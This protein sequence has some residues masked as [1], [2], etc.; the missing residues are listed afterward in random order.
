MPTIDA[1]RS[2]LPAHLVDVGGR[3][4]AI[5]LG[6]FTQRRVNHILRLAGM[7]L[8]Y[9]SPASGGALAVWGRDDAAE[10]IAQSRKARLITI[11]DAFL[12]SLHPGRAG[13][14]PLG[15]MVDD[16]GLYYDAR[17]PSRL[18]HI[19]SHDPLDDGAILARARAVIARMRANHLSKYSATDPEA[20]APKAGYVLVLDQVKGDRAIAGGGADA[21]RFS[22]ML[23]CAMAEHPRAP[24]LIKSHPETAQ[25]LRAGYF[26][27]AALHLAD[28]NGERVSLYRG[29][30]SPWVLYEGAIAVYTVTS[31]G[32]FEA[33][34]AGHKPVTFGQPFYAGWGLSED[35]FPVARR[36]RRLTRAQLVAGAMILAPLW[37]DPHHRRL[38]Q[39][40]DALGHLE[41]QSRAW[42]ADRHGYVAYGM[43]AW[44]RPHLRHFFGRDIR[45]CATPERAFAMARRMGKPLLVWSTKISDAFRAQAQGLRV[46]FVEDGFLRSRG[47]GAAL[48]PPLSLLTDQGGP[49]YDAR[50]AS[51]LERAIAASAR[52]DPAL[53]PR[54]EGLITRIT[55]RGL[56]KYNLTPTPPTPPL[57]PRDGR[58]RVLVVGQVEDD[59]S[60]RHGMGEIVTNGALLAWAREKFPDRFL[61]YKPHPDVVAGLRQGALEGA[62]ADHILT[63][64]DAATILSE[65][66]HVVVMSSGMGFE[67]LLRGLPVSV[68]GMPFYAGWGLTDDALPRPQARRAQIDLIGLTHAALIA[69]PRYLDPI[70]GLPASVEVALDRIARGQT[71]RPLWLTL[72]AALQRPFAFGLRRL[73]R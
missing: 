3:V 61:I 51:D 42:R 53:R 25:G 54:V 64:G 37:Y 23:A 31:Q 33:I 58:K 32:G 39:I 57:P 27:A 17:R 30:L 60:L 13:E 65:V 29:D 48:T 52:L 68:A 24:I 70:T 49:H 16:M 66:D 10:A 47:L 41:A 4:H 5:S 12:R 8:S 14:P 21:S 72:M 20:P 36:Q 50:H 44:K 73:W 26:D 7:R 18:E 69:A 62:E 1:A 38:C 46:I 9:G 34:L 55:T 22:E 43:S 56:T 45:F 15:L 35:R 19:L 40:E 2:P 6:F 71:R 11:E 59:A 67:A 28:P 63:D